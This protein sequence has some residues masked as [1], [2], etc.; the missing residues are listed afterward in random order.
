MVAGAYPGCSGESGKEDDGALEREARRR[1]VSREELSYCVVVGAPAA[2]G[3]QGF[4]ERVRRSCSEH[5][6]ERQAFFGLIAEQRGPILIDRRLV[7]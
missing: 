6:L 4:V 5:R 1:T 7:Q 3:G 2:A